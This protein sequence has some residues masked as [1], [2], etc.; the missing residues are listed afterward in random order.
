MHWQTWPGPIAAIAVA[1][2]CGG[3]DS[4]PV[5]RPSPA[6]IARGSAP[7][8]CPAPTTEIAR[9]VERLDDDADEL[10]ADITPAVLSLSDHGLAG[11]CAVLDDLDAPSQMR[12]L[13]AARV[14]EYVVAK[15]AGFRIG[16][17]HRDQYGDELT[18]SVARTTDYDPWAP[19]P[20]R[21]EGAARWRAWVER[22]LVSSSLID[23]RDGPTRAEMIAALAARE[24]EFIAC[25]EPVDLRVTFD[26]TGVVS[27]IFR[28]DSPAS[29]QRC[30]AEAART[31][32]IRPFAR[33]SVWIRYRW[34]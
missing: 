13:H 19:R 28:S 10:H 30:V 12:R 3:R 25:G 16:R 34:E 32:R 4:P 27:S 9:L 14:L 24:P 6:A 23:P 2:A 5:S 29:Y 21:L 22:E 17:G 26:R 11:A 20:A 18:A 8:P 1:I 31:I 7:S 15:Y 33:D